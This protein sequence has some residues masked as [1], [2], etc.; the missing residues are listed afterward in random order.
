MIGDRYHDV[1]GAKANGIGCIG[2]L[3]GFGDREELL[4]AG[5]VSVA[6]TAYELEKILLK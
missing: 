5:A 6:E 1:E 4:G 3:F 2:V